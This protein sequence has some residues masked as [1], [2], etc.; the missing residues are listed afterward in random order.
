[1]NKLVVSMCVLLMAGAANAAVINFEFGSL[2]GAPLPRGTTDITLG[3][4]ET[5][6]INV[7]VE[8]VE[9]GFPPA[10]EQLGLLT[11]ALSLYE[12]PPGAFVTDPTDIE[13]VGYSNDLDPMYTYNNVPGGGG[14]WTLTEIVRVDPGNVI[15]GP[16]EY[17]VSD[18]IVHC[19]GI[20]SL[21]QIM[22]LTP[23]TDLLLFK[24]DLITGIDYTLGTG[25]TSAPLNITQVPEPATIGL[26][27]LSGFAVLRRRR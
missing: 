2:N 10:P 16:G 4:S 17:L 14:A 21:D 19:L 26:L 5:A 25:S 15:E 27:A 18:I 7:Y 20:P 8:L 9:S 22:I 12:T 13:I 23:S 6:V 3:L 11:Y 24:P 1:M